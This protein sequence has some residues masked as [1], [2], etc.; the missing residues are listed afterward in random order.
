[1]PWSA[2]K[3]EIGQG[4]LTA[5]TQ[6][7]AEE[8][9]LRPTSRSISI[10]G[11][12][13]AG[14][15]KPHLGRLLGLVGGARSVRRRLP[16]VR[17]LYLDRL[18]DNAEVPSQANSRSRTENSSARAKTPAAT[19]GRMKGEISLE[20]RVTAAAPTKS[21]SKYKIVGK[22]MPRLDLPAKVSGAAFIHDMLPE[23]VVHAR[24][25]RQ[26]WRYA[27]RV[28]LNEAAIRKAAKEPIEIM[29]EGNFVAFTGT[30]EIAVLRAAQAAREIAKWE[31][32]T[33]TPTASAR[34][35]G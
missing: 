12:A 2:G 29:R 6:I 8:L 10:S 27:N 20:R 3:V 30:S 32:G 34:P 4:I 19:T 35:N 24:V 31:G 28:E 18:A 1:M 16:E 21:P 14:R 13:G 33:P 23:G 7:A 26:P 5:I 25:L 9:D 17:S 15:M 11:R 22:S